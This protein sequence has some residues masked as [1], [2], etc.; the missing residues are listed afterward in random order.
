[1]LNNNESAAVPFSKKIHE[2]NKACVYVVKKKTILGW[3]AASGEKITRWLN[4]V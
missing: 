4:C 3:P 2:L 1:L